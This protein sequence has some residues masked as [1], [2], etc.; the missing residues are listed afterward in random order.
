MEKKNGEYKLTIMGALNETNS[1]W[2]QKTAPVGAGDL[3][4][5][6][7]TR[8]ECEVLSSILGNLPK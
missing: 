4:Q 6:H 8:L 1:M 2:V 3:A 5:W 7:S